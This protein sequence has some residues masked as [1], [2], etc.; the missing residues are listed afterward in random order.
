MLPQECTDDLLA[1]SYRNV[2]AMDI[3]STPS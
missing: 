2:Y 3:S 1:R